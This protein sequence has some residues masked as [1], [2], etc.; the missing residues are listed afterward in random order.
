VPNPDTA[1]VPVAPETQKPR[2]HL[3]PC[4]TLLVAD[5]PPHTQAAVFDVDAA[6]HNV[7]T[8]WHPSAHCFPAIKFKELI[9]LDHVC[10]FGATPT[11]GLFGRITDMMVKI[12]LFH[13]IDV[14][15]K[16]VD[17]FIF[18]CYPQLSIKNDS[19]TY[20]YDAKFIWEIAE[21]LGWPWAH[22]KFIDFSSSFTYIGFWWI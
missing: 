4:Y 17:D 13:G 18:F 8:H 14:L 9:H 20:S 19:P 11:P 16:W 21:E 5:T 7:P 2:V 22:S 1:P 10:N 12:L 6:F 3:Y 15:I